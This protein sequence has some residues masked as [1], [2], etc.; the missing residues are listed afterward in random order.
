MYYSVFGLDSP[1]WELASP[2]THINSIDTIPP[3]QIFHVDS[4]RISTIVSNQLFNEFNDNNQIAEVIPVA[5]S[6]H[7]LI[8]N[9]FGLENDVVSQQALVFIQTIREELSERV[10]SNNF[11]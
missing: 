6:S 7:N 4:R 3:F 10:F 8:N 2:L 9:N 11:E 1:I 5:N